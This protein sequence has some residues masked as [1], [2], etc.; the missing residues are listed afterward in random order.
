MAQDG[1]DT[2]QLG[3]GVR[4]DEAVRPCG[5]V[6]FGEADQQLQVGPVAPGERGEDGVG[7]QGVLDEAERE[8]LLLAGEHVAEV[9]HVGAVG[10]HVGDAEAPAGLGVG[11]TGH[12]Y[13]EALAPQVVGA[14]G[15]SRRS[16]DLDEEESE[17]VGDVFHEGRL[18]VARR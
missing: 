2:V 18:A 15:R 8:D 4:V 6:A 3:R 7:G 5:R 1:E 11:V 16:A 9:P 13:G 14:S 10:D 17:P 12:G